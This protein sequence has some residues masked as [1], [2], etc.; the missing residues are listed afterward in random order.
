MENELSFDA[1]TPPEDLSVE[2]VDVRNAVFIVPI[3]AP[4]PRELDEMVSKGDLYARL[5]PVASDGD[6]MS[7]VPL[8][9]PELLG[10]SN[11]WRALAKAPRVYVLTGLPG[12]RY[13]V[14][15]SGAARQIGLRQLDWSDA[16][17]T[18]ARRKAR[19][20]ST[21]DAK[22]WTASQQQS[23]AAPRVVNPRAPLPASHTSLPE[24]SD[25]GEVE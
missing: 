17:E 4:I 15:F 2:S 14:T 22:P 20:Q 9:G 8:S 23:R 6:G 16:A 13:D 21:A 25:E 10:L 7:V 19:E 1:L 3:D 11:V 24:P 5:G 12:A 18:M